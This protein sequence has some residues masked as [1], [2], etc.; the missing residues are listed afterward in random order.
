MTAIFNLQEPGEHPYC[1]DGINLKTGFSYTPELLM[2][3]GISYFNF[4]W[5]D[6]TNPTFE[7]LLNITQVMDFVIK[8]GGKVLVHCHAGQGRTALVIGAYLIYSGI[9][10]N[11]AESIKL[12]RLNRPKCFSKGYNCKFIQS[13]DEQLK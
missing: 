12:T 2:N 1:G 7:R 13:F 8:N 3:A 10:R 6:L 5:K 4:Y 11:A 9:A